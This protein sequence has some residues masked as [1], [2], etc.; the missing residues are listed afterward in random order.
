MDYPQFFALLPAAPRKACE[1]AYDLA[2][3]NNG[4]FKAAADKAVRNRSMQQARE[5]I[6]SALA[7]GGWPSAEAQDI[8]GAV[9][10]EEWAIV[11]LATTPPAA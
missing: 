11:Q 5:A 6:R 7:A 1:A 9:V 2:S 8:A 4:G 10:F 3:V